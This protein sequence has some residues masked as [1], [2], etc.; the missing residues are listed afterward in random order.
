[1]AVRHPER[2]VIFF[3]WDGTLGD[4]MDLCLGEIR[5]ALKRIG[6]AEVEEERIRAC[7]GPTHE[8]SVKI[9]ELDAEQGE[10]FL[11][12]R[13]RAELELIPVL[14]KLY[15]GVDG[16]VE[17]LSRIADLAIVSNG[18]KDYVEHSVMQF[19][20]EGYFVRI[21]ASIPGLGKTEVLGKMLEEMKPVRSVLAGDRRGD[22]EAGIGQHLPTLAAAYGY[23]T[24][25][26]YAL[27][28]VR[29]QTPAEMEKLLEKWVRT[30]A[31]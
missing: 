19:S 22:M 31:F 29:A 27:A 26:E 18:Q 6:H 30:G 14:L 3:D 28:D 13:R 9:M 15:P 23:G 20:L 2:P 11:R 12:E 8:E 4:S 16:I 24:E 1:M 7:N 17:R 10:R 21:Q 5:Q 25:E